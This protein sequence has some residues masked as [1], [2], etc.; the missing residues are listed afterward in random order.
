MLKNYEKVD[1]DMSNTVDAVQDSIQ[2]AN[3][4]TVD[5]L[6]SPEIELAI[7]P[8]NASSGHDAASFTANSECG[9]DVG[10][11]VAFGNASGNNNV[12]QVSDVNDETR[13]NI[14]DELDELS[15]P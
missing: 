12:L 4:T 6:V 8:I 13:K 11:I 15:V 1:R 5:S 10:F 7:K 3:L 14:P 2:N 9:E